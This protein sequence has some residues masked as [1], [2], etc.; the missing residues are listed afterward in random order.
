MPFGAGPRVCSGN[1]FAL[2]EL[3]RMLATWMRRMRFDLEANATELLCE[4]LITLRP[5][6][7][8]VGRVT[9]RA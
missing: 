9:A 5:R 1:H 4:P 7:G 8:V 3:Q 2:M 6:G